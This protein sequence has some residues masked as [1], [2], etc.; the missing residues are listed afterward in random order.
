VCPTGGWQ[1]LTARPSR[2]HGSLAE[3]PS[4]P[5]A[6]FMGLCRYRSPHVG[7]Q[8]TIPM[9]CQNKRRRSAQGVACP[10]GR[11]RVM[12]SACGGI[13]EM[14]G[15][16]DPGEGR[17]HNGPVSWF[18]NPPDYSCEPPDYVNL[19]FPRKSPGRPRKTLG[20][21]LDGRPRATATFV[22]YAKEAPAKGIRGL[23]CPGWSPS[24]NPPLAKPVAEASSGGLSALHGPPPLCA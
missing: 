1:Q 13:M 12:A 20:G 2:T 4:V 17:S 18:L 14:L 3:R 21:G 19:T 11:K 10:E 8:P 5:S 7:R 22:V 23:F 15:A 16:R 24:P 9:S 6:E